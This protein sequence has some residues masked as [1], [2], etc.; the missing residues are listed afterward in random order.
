MKKIIFS[1]LMTLSLISNVHAIDQSSL[2][3]LKRQGFVVRMGELTGAGSKLSMARL[4]GF[5]HPQGIVMIGDCKNIV[6]A[7]TSDQTDP[8]ISDI[9]KVTIDQSVISASEF[10]GFFV[11]Q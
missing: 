4:A 11:F 5:I 8:K 2:D 9:T 1:L 7:K 6:I 10:E 3:Q